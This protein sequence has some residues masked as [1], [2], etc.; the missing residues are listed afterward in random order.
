MTRTAICLKTKEEEE[1]VK[2][3]FDRLSVTLLYAR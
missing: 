3:H 1:K 2:P